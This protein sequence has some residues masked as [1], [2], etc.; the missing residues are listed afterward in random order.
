MAP[1][2]DAALPSVAEIRRRL[3]LIFPEQVDPRGWARREMA[4]KTVFVMLYGYAVEGYDR[5]IRPTAVTDM[6]DL[7]AARI[8]P[9]QR[10]SWLT[11]VQGSRRPREIIGRWYRENTREPIRDETLRT[12]VELG[13]VLERPGIPTTSSKPRYALTRGF[14]DLFAPE[15]AE[16]HLDAAIA[17][18][19]ESNLSATARA[20]LVLVRSGAGPVAQDFLVSLPNGETRRIAQGPS[21]SLTQAVVEEFAPRFLGSPAVVLLSESAQKLTYG[22]EALARAIGF[23]IQVSCTLPDVILADL[24]GKSPLIVFVECVATD[25]AVTDRR[26]AE[27]A[28][29]AAKGGFP[30]SDCAYVTVFHDRA[31]SPFTRIAA[32]LAWGSFVWFAT[33]PDNILF[34]HEGRED[35]QVRLTSLLRP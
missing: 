35:F 19:Q 27:L 25:G 33:E 32:S 18:W 5:W 12:L 6:T 9:E 10:E 1:W 20:R 26:R 21:A 22:D 29:L 14:T 13:A 24:D 23:D 2:L 7:Q 17:E 11:L 15:V 3:K 31:S 28:S 8:E 30:P 34:L 16:D 4:A